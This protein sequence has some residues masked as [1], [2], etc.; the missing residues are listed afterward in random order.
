MALSVLIMSCGAGRSKAGG[1][2]NDTMTE[3]SGQEVASRVPEFS[4]D[5]AFLYLKRQVEFGPRV[6]GSEAHVRTADWLC[7]ELRRHGAEVM[8]QK[9]ELKA[10]D[11]TVLKCRNIF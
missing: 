1:N 10:F 9:A 6:P 5:S 2:N 4:A 8:E 3:I 7:G 11:G